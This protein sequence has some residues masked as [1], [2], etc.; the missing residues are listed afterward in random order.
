MFRAIFELCIAAFLW[1]FSFIAARWGLLG[2]SPY[3]LTSLRFFLA[4]VL[5]WVA[6]R[7]F[8][9]KVLSTEKPVT[10]CLAG[11]SLGLAVTLQVVGLQLTSVARNS[12]LTT[13]Y[14]VFL[15]L[16]EWLFL[17][18]RIS[19]LHLLYV[20]LA[21]FGT[22]L[23]CGWVSDPWNLGDGLTLVCAIL[24]AGHILLVERSSRLVQSPLLFNAYQSLWA[25]VPPLFLAW[26]APLFFSS[27]PGLAIAGLLFL[28]LG[29][30]IV[31]F[32]IQIRTQRILSPGLASLFF[33]LESPIATLFGVWL[34]N[35]A[36]TLNQ[37]FGGT[38]IL[39]AALGATYS[40]VML[41]KSHAAAI[42]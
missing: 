15:P 21:T 13:L 28:V 30:S 6:L 20:G 25:S 8:R 1:G 42:K 14:I 16:L 32:T 37:I 19:P 17:Q 29:V 40:Q 3:W 26:Q 5:V 35:E 27:L 2:F 22:L 23:M 24:S 11:L 4:F 33:L 9:P 18:R 38:C 31:A 39:I 10:A 36:V 7:L 12:F 41:S 34:L